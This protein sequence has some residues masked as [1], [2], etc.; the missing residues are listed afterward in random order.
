MYYPDF[1]EFKKMTK[2][3][4]LIPVYTEIYA[5][6]ETPV[7]AFIKIDDGK[8]SF[9]YESIEG[10]EKWA[11]YSFLGTSP[12]LV[13]KC[14]GNDVDITINGKTVRTGFVSDP[15]EIL[16]GIMDNYSPVKV[17]GL[18]RFTG[19]AI[20]FL[21]YDFVRFFEKLPDTAQD[22]LDLRDAVFMLMDSIVI[23]DNLSHK[24]KIV[25]NA[26][27][28]EGKTPESAYRD[29]R[30]RIE[31][32]IDKLKKSKSRRETKKRS[33]KAGKL[34][35]I[36]NFTREKFVKAVEKAKAY[37]RAGD[38]IQVVLSQR[39]SAAFDGSPFAVYRALRIINPSPYMFFLKLGDICMAGS[40]PEILVRVE[41]G[42]IELRP[43][44]G[45]RPRGKS[46][47]ED[48]K[49]EKDLLA[50]P[51]ER[52][53]HIML[54]DLGRNDVGR[55]AKTATVEVNELMAVERYSHVMHIVS[56][57]RGRL[58]DN[59]NVFDVIRACF[60]AG[61]VSGAPKIRAME[62]IEELEPSRRGAYA[63]AVGYFSFSGNMDTCINIRTLVFH[64]GKVYIQGGAGIVADSVPESEYTET[65]N[66]MKA[67]LEALKLS[68]ELGYD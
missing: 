22:T 24:M 38:V 46:E 66:K 23:F 33:F 12:S 48:K 59:N 2:M 3:G 47:D 64:K 10:G 36:S 26:H 1:K 15:L 55:V 34:Q 54:V 6:M 28:P 35:P 18:P 4:N 14:K 7:S 30:K 50:D 27:I 61:T 51:K 17:K 58:A 53:E 32:I 16:R 20:G 63:G 62:I 9:L 11:R 39:F 57:V 60:P 8:Y 68:D 42:I 5:D 56:N 65:M 41:D 52:A 44:A 29:A 21:G 40:S 19:G 13:F 49:L 67:M 37:I 45:T 25:A 31:G 43:I